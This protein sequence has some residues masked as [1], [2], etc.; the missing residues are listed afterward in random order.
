MRMCYY[1]EKSQ[2]RRG[3][4]VQSKIWVRRQWLLWSFPSLSCLET[5]PSLAFWITV[6]HDWGHESTYASAAF[7][8]PENGEQGFLL[9]CSWWQSHPAAT[10]DLSAHEDLVIRW[11]GQ[12]RFQKA[13]G[14]ERWRLQRSR[15]DMVYSRVQRGRQQLQ[16][17]AKRTRLATRTLGHF[18]NFQASHST[19]SVKRQP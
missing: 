5:L 6:V 10:S 7:S 9:G 13:P 19:N 17:Q 14:R 15:K 1:G 3:I 16:P 12:S 8:I 11:R 2:R 4:D 18:M